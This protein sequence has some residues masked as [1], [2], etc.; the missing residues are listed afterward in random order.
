MEE[1]HG[2]EDFLHKIPHFGLCES[3]PP[4]GQLHQAA[5]GAA[6]EQYIDE[7]L[8]FKLSLE[9]DDI[10]VREVAVELDLRDQLALMLAADQF[11]FVDDFACVDLGGIDRLHSV[12]IGEPA[13]S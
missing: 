4:H 6:F 10:A 7:L 8:V 9:F 5:V 13:F 1:L 12:H 3:L 11:G 2:D